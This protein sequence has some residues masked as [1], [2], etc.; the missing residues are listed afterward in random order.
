MVSLSSF[1]EI[2]Y[3]PQDLEWLGDQLG[4]SDANRDGEISKR[5]FNSVPLASFRDFYQKQLT[6]EERHLL[7]SFKVSA[8]LSHKSFL[9]HDTLVR[10]AQ[11]QLRYRQYDLIKNRLQLPVDKVVTLPAAPAHPNTDFT[12]MNFD[13][14]RIR[15]GLSLA[16]WDLLNK[17][18]LSEAEKQRFPSPLIH[19][20][21]DVFLTHRSVNQIVITE[22]AWQKI[23]TKLAAQNPKDFA[24]SSPASTWNEL[25]LVWE[26]CDDLRDNSLP[27]RIWR[28]TLERVDNSSRGNDFNLIFLPQSFAISARGLKEFL[29]APQKFHV[30]LSTRVPSGPSLLDE[31]KLHWELG[32]P[33][34]PTQIR[35][36][37][38]KV[39]GKK[40]PAKGIEL[41][42]LNLDIEEK[43]RAVAAQNADNGFFDFSLG[44]PLLWLEGFRLNLD[45]GRHSRWLAGFLDL[46]AGAYGRDFDVESLE[47]KGITL[48]NN[49][50]CLVLKGES[51]NRRDLVKPLFRD[52]LLIDLSQIIKNQLDKRP[53]SAPLSALIFD[54]QANVTSQIPTADL[55]KALFDFLKSNSISQNNGVIPFREF[56]HNFWASDL[57]LSP[58]QNMEIKRASLHASG[59]WPESLVVKGLADI[60]L[61]INNGGRDLPL[62]GALE[63][64]L[65]FRKKSGFAKL[66][67]P[68]L[69]I[70]GEKEKASAQVLAALSFDPAELFKNGQID[71]TAVLKKIS[72]SLLIEI[73]K[74]QKTWLTALAQ[75][76]KLQTGESPQVSAE[77]DAAFL[78]P[79]KN[80]FGLLSNV[81]LTITATG[82]REWIL[83][84]T[85]G[86]IQIAKAGTQKIDAGGLK[87]EIKIKKGGTAKNPVFVVTISQMA[88]NI[89]DA[90]INLDKAKLRGRTRATLSGQWQIEADSFSEVLSGESP[91]HGAGD[92]V[93]DHKNSD[94]HLSNG[95]SSA[96]LSDAN[97]QTTIHLS[98]ISFP[99]I[100]AE[101]MINHHI[102]DGNLKIESPMLEIESDIS[103]SVTASGKL[104]TVMFSAAPKAALIS[105]A[106][107]DKDKPGIPPN[108]T[109]LKP[110][111]F[112]NNLLAPVI[113]EIF[114]TKNTPKN[115][116]FYL[117]HN[118]PLES[119][120]A[121]IKAA[122]LQIGEI[123]LAENGFYRKGALNKEFTLIPFF[124]GAFMFLNPKIEKGT[125]ASMKP[126]QNVVVND[127]L[128]DFKIDLNPPIR[129]LGRRITGIGLA[130]CHFSGKAKR[131]HLYLL[132]PMGRL[133]LVGFLRLAFPC[134][135]AKIY[136]LLRRDG[137]RVQ[138]NEI[139]DKMAE[140][141]RFLRHFIDV[142]EFERKVRE[143]NER[144]VL[145][146]TAEEF[147]HMTARQKQLSFQFLAKT[148]IAKQVKRGTNPLQVYFNRVAERQDLAE[149]F[150]QN[151]DQ[152]GAETASR[153]K[154]IIE[155]IL[156]LKFMNAKN[157]L[158]QEDRDNIIRNNRRLLRLFLKPYIQTTNWLNGRSIKDIHADITL[159]PKKGD[160]GI[161]TFKENASSSVS[162]ALKLNP[163]QYTHPQMDEILPG[164]Y[165]SAATVAG[166][167][168]ENVFFNLKTPTLWV[169]G[170]F[171]E[172]RK[173]NYY[174]APEN[175]NGEMEFMVAFENA[176]VDNLNVIHM[177]PNRLTRPKFA[178]FS[179]TPSLVGKSNHLQ[180]GNF[181]LGFLEDSYHYVMDVEKLNSDSTYAYF[182]VG[183]NGKERDMLINTAGANFTDFHFDTK[184]SRKSP[185]E[186]Y[187][188][189]L[190]AVK[191]HIDLQDDL[192]QSARAL[193]YIGDHPEDGREYLVID[194]L[195]ANG[196]VDMEGDQ[197]RCLANMHLKANIPEYLRFIPALEKLRQ[198]GITFD[199]KSI[200]L[201]GS[202]LLTLDE[203]G[204]SVKRETPANAIFQATQLYLHGN[205]EI[206][207]KDSKIKLSEIR[208]PLSELAFRMKKILNDK[209]QPFTQT[210]LSKIVI[211]ANEAGQ[212]RLDLSLR[213]P[214][215]LG[216]RT[217]EIQNGELGISSKSPLIFTSES[218]QSPAFNT[219][220]LSIRANDSHNINTLDLS[221][222]LV[223]INREGGSIQNWR[224]DAQLLDLILDTAFAILLEGKNLQI[225]VKNL[226]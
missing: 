180:G 133:D 226:D 97:Q 202:L 101:G 172:I 111:D 46:I 33:A 124:E 162:A 36:K 137:I 82:D 148:S 179:P 54:Q 169:R 108:F 146:F 73:K 16:E 149:Y 84:P 34:R 139:P 175:K 39:G 31:G 119:M 224:L 1:T 96:E 72:A 93:I 103:G 151:L 206:Q 21:R 98:D 150:D 81:G 185:E 75:N 45:A 51:H 170:D 181:Y 208:L 65:D 95:K 178:L 78:L 167:Q 30:S 143:K 104:P 134:K 29:V 216:Q 214:E 203:D 188:T 59:R 165:L 210:W 211:P 136:Q 86:R 217:F 201:D 35:L 24:Q 144:Q 138:P 113:D 74:N 225:K 122:T 115:F 56:Q 106:S 32:W 18:S 6:S 70:F 47:A 52:L 79:K 209:N 118:F 14:S 66:D 184:L 182:F 99:Q 40:N 164:F 163:T 27:R 117:S 123:P 4:L 171:N 19:L 121:S 15:A 128:Q 195:I 57:S 55:I 160:Y 25:M 176:D 158:S 161:V 8:P 157:G 53:A 87:G 68:Q 88:I 77:I 219:E 62:K 69:K 223:Q 64:Y 174:L 187:M 50:L 141:G 145:P 109:D 186:E 192:S 130:D 83:S 155:E 183:Q 63:F 26:K 140:L 207:L 127:E 13:I 37:S 135:I 205:F 23:F 5:E 125:K 213:L 80:I 76:L 199:F 177:P 61:A 3:D 193:L 194:K 221:T 198:K 41:A 116:D 168:L 153:A 142:F 71:T 200:S 120:L 159:K 12:S 154:T 215:K 114:N 204:G 147:S 92:L 131:K 152:F 112:I 43:A 28:N 17:A 11:K 94:L 49:R 212:A 58:A 129:F 9:T 48:F 105:L 20:L 191:G 90:L 42:A 126:A 132:T 7:G 91:W 60:E 156:L 38:F 102:Q 189:A 197:I 44:K 85:A 218:A 10:M 67:L 22:N 222:G 166:E 110:R 100:E 89:E 2:I 190:N 220:G 196:D 107:T 173:L